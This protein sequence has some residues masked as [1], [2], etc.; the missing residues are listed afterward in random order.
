MGFV[1][2]L[3]DRWRTLID[4]AGE[5]AALAA[6]AV[7]LATVV[8][9]LVAIP[10]R[11]RPWLA[12]ACVAAGGTLLLVPSLATLGLLALVIDRRDLAALI[13]VAICAVG[14]VLRGAVTGFRGVDPATL[15]A[16]AGTGMTS[17]E[18]FARVE[19][20]LAWPAI[21]AGMRVAT[22]IAL[23][24]GAAAAVI[25]G[26]GLGEE[27]LLGLSHAGRDD[28]L[29]IALGGVL[30]V[31]ALGILSEAAYALARRLTVSRGIR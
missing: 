5:H 14:P 28:A 15:E 19:L 17:G 9:L 22:A 18:R 10:A 4:L 21:L 7:A 11:R 20:R 2:H 12:S 24:I 25:D 27:I 29:D 23:G 13:A 1:D 26:P 3:T 30:A 16:A 6:L 31:L 8:A